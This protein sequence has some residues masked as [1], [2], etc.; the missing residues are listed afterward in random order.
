MLVASVKTVTTITMIST[1]KRLLINEW[2][3][4]NDETLSEMSLDDSII[5]TVFQFLDS[6]ESDIEVIICVLFLI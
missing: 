1:T 5:E 3:S 6:I 4:S 2:L